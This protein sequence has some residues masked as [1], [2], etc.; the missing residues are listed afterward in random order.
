MDII[1]FVLTFIAVL[2]TAL[3]AG[4]FFAFS[5]F[6]M[7]AL[8]GLSAERGIVA[9]QA[10]IRAI[11]KIAFLVLFFGTAVLCAA[12]GILALLRWGTPGSTLTLLGA[13]FFLAGAFAVTMLCSLPLNSQLLAAAPDA[14]NMAS[15]W[16]YFQNAWVRWNHIR[17]IATLMA[18]ACFVLA[19]AAMG[20]PF[21]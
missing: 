13:V 5:A 18:C 21:R 4:S 20:S 11:K 16:R 19:L 7:R 3:L 8:H 1:L 14:P 17:T 6:F 12:L 15:F 9:M 10:T 2:C